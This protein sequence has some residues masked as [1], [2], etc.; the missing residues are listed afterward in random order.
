MWC[1]TIRKESITH[2]YNMAG[3]LKLNRE[4]KCQGKVKIQIFHFLVYLEISVSI[5]LEQ[6]SLS[7]LA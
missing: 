1:L 3:N 4:K 2:D 6:R 5:L 7:S